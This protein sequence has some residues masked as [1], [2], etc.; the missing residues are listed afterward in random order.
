MRVGLY[1]GVGLEGWHRWSAHAFGG[2][3]VC[4]VVW[5][6]GG[7]QPAFAPCS[8]EAAFEFFGLF[9]SFVQNLS[10]LRMHSCVS[11]PMVSLYF[12]APGEVCP[13]KALQQKVLG[14]SHSPL[15]KGLKVSSSET[16]FCWTGATDPSLP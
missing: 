6:L 3:P 5:W 1:L 16:S 11:S 4:G 13:E 12:V 14:L 2:G 15:L 7:G 8:S 9:V 10:Q